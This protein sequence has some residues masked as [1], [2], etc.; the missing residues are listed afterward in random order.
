MS[1]PAAKPEEDS[2]P[3]S[4][5]DAFRAE[6]QRPFAEAGIPVNFQRKDRPWEPPVT[7]PF[8]ADE[9]SAVVVRMRRGE[10]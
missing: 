1:N 5:P 2:G 8:P 7:L 6:L 9:A 3:W 10:D 4:D